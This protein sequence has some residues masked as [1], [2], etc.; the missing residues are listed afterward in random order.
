ML[1]S[2]TTRLPLLRRWGCSYQLVAGASYIANHSLNPRAFAT[3]SQHPQPVLLDRQ[4]TLKSALLALGIGVGAGATYWVFFQPATKKSQIPLQPKVS[5]EAMSTRPT[6]LTSQQIDDRLRA[7][8]TRVKLDRLDRK[9]TVVAGYELNRVNSNDPIEDYHDERRT[10]TGMIFAVYDGHSGT[11]CADVL[12]KYLSSYVAAA[13]AA[14]PKS[15]GN[16]RQVEI[17]NAIKQAFLRMDDDITKGSIITDPNY[18]STFPSSREIIHAALRPAM[19]GSCALLAYIEGHDLYVACTGDSRAVLGSLRQDGSYEAEPLSVDQ[20]AANP[21][22]HARMLEEHPGERETVLVNGRVLGGLMPTRAFGDCR[23]KWSK[24]VADALVPPLFGK[25]VP[26]NY[27]SPPYVTA[28]PEVI[29]VTLNP[30]RDRFLILATDGVWDFLSSEEGVD[31]VGRHLS[32]LDSNGSELVP[33]PLDEGV[34]LEERNISI[35]KDSNSATHLIRNALVSAAGAST[36]EQLGKLLAIPPPY[37]R[38]YRD[39]MTAIIVHF[40]DGT[41]NRDYTA[42]ESCGSGTGGQMHEVDLSL[43]EPKKPRIDQT[44]SWA[45]AN[46]PSGIGPGVNSKKN[47]KFPSNNENRTSKNGEN[48]HLAVVSRL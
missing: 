45:V 20:T 47:P 5:D 34:V 35:F 40:H 44:S 39:D 37:S 32:R 43:T 18:K 3:S 38:R 25:S 29:R 4:F 10:A 22:E 26:R 28:K 21:S 8:E 41:F 6:G 30:A 27:G 48:E 23:Y 1:F 33:P 9:G 31:L 13:I 11:E 16:I 42:N 7:A 36:D 14:I 24:A 17:S 15:S 46:L 19:A 2:G 12:S